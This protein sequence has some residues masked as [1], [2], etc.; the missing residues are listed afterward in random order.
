MPTHRTFLPAA[1]V[2]LVATAG[3]P[4]A[5]K[6]PSYVKDVKPFLKTYCMDCH[7]DTKA[8]SGY[9]VET[10]AS[11][12]KAGKRGALVVAGKPDA[13]RLLMTLAGDGKA[14]PPK[15]KPQPKAEEIA[16]VRDW[17][18]AGAR[19]DSGGAEVARKPAAKAGKKGDD[20]D[21]DDRERGDHKKRRGERKERDD[22]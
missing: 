22:D 13:S 19:D 7:N 1:L 10:F 20:D 21:D 14:M 16:R 8:R 12:T 3:A 4:A 18:K 2:L 9:S 5:P 11:L 15:N 17:I 6:P